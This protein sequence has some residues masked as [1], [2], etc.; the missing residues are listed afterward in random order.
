MEIFG[1]AGWSGSG[2]TT[3]MVRLVPELTAL[4]LRVSTMKHAHHAFDVDQPGKDSFNHRAAGATEVLI[5]SANRWALMHENRGDPEPSIE[6]LV[7]HMTPV[8]LLLIEGFKRSP[9]PKLEVFRRSTGK[10]LLALE[11]PT[12]V[13]VACDDAVPEVAVPVLDLNYPAAIAR[14]VVTQCGINPR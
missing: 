10:P 1:I 2:K 3:L 6:E 14:F 12:V 7:G 8:D 5:T 4:G 9:H 13:A 11:D